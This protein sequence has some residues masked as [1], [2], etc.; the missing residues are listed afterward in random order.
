MA[1][2]SRW[3]SH[4][5]TVYLLLGNVCDNLRHSHADRLA[6]D[7]LVSTG[8]HRIEWRWVKGPPGDP[9]NERADALANRGVDQALGRR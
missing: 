9:G 3:R 7:A 5:T 8:G 1:V 6:L 4:D 2:K